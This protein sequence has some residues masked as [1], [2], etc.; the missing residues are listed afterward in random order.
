MLFAYPIVGIFLGYSLLQVME[1][2]TSGIMKVKNYFKTHAREATQSH[3]VTNPGD[4][5]R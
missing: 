1:Y 3:N 4:G 2:F 5:H